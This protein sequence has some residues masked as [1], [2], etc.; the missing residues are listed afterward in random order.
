M[1]TLPRR[2]N[3]PGIA[4]L[5][6]RRAG[7]F[8]A[9]RWRGEVP[10]RRLLWRDMLGIGTAVNILATFVALMVAS[11]GASAWVAVAI[12]FAPLPYN[13]FLVAAVHRA[14]SR[15]SFTLTLALIWLVVVT[16]V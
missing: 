10:L 3:R 1:A 5:N 11:Q 4:D 9:R 12:H 16:V 2:G 8:F 14:A 6:T 13:V 15:S 7:N